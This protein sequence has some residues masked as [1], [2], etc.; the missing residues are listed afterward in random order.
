MAKYD[1]KLAYYYIEGN[2]DKI[3]SAYLGMHEDWW[4]TASVIFENGEY[5]VDLNDE[6]LVIAG[7]SGSYW[8][9][10]TMEVNFKDGSTKTFKCCEGESTGQTPVG[11]GGVITDQVT[12]ARNMIVLEN[13][14]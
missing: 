2:K 1:Y 14:N 7:I 10:P 5:Q 9:T 11:F 8:A 3:E 12:A 6:D 4:W 13:I